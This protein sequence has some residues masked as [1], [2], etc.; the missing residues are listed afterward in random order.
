M[1]VLRYP[2]R[3]I[4]G[5]LLRAGAGAS[6]CALAVLL[7]EPPAWLRLL[8]LAALLAFAVFGLRASAR[9]RQGFALEPGE[10][11]VLHRGARLP[12]SA[13]R[14]LK[15]SYFS[16]RRDHREGWLELV[17]GFEDAS[18]RVDS[19]L[20]GFETLLRQA[21]IA[22]RDNHV[23][24]NAATLRNVTWLGLE[25]LAPDGPRAGATPDA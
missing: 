25:A 17:L 4:L 22:A 9:G 6:V 5:D 15:L 11:V 3:A 18:I 21:I 20:Q 24:M 7:V 10:L 16:T 13:L 8:L 14:R 2:P 19:R 23:D 12:W 1:T